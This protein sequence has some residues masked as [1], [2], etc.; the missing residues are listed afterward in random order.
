MSS[1][2]PRTIALKPPCLLRIYQGVS[3]ASGPLVTLYLRHRRRAG[4]EDTVR[5]AERLG[6]ASR[7]RPDGLLIWFHAASVGE[8]LSVARLIERLMSERPGSHVLI[9]TGTVTS[10]AM[11]ARRLGDRAIHQFVPADRPKWVARFLDHWRP[12]CAI[13]VESEIWPNLLSALS[14]RQIPAALI[15]AR[16]SARSFSR[17]RIAPRSIARLLRSFELCLAQTP[18][19]A[20]R[21]EQLGTRDVRAVGQLKYA[22]DRLPVDPATLDSCARAIGSRPVW[23]LAS[24][25]DGEEA[26]AIAAHRLVQRGF[27]DVLTVIVPRH[28]GRSRGIAALVRD[29]G[30]GASLRS[31]GQPPD[32]RDDIYVVDAMGELGLWYRLATVACIGGTLAPIGGHNPIEA[33]QL[34]C[35]I[36]HGPHIGNIR[37]IVAELESARA[38]WPVA[39]ADGL[40][41]ALFRLFSE[42]DRAREMAAS[43]RAV[44]DRN[45]HVIYRVLAALNPLID[46]AA[47]QT[48]VS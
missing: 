26:V 9:T 19:E 3:A 5:F 45:A 12:D 13:W 18:A 44:A 43:A 33:A 48:S 27:P 38:A 23:V 42:P 37:E 6:I 8:A 30:L 46:R 7:P 39:D 15:N 41:Q 20:L 25:H 2:A 32:D 16:M 11:V 14:A 29:A 35:A 24:S 36:L 17:W 1:S 34:D 21:L 4:R 31:T 28:V 47:R 22:A 10:A 40:A